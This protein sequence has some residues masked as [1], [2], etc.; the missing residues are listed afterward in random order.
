MHS[1]NDIFS[2]SK[3]DLILFQ[4]TK[5]SN[6]P[7]LLTMSKYKIINFSSKKPNYGG[8]LSAV[9]Q[10]PISITKGIGIEEFDNEGRV[11]TLE[12]D[13]FFVINAYF[14]FAGDFL[15][16]IDAKMSFL[17]EFERHCMDLKNKKPLIICGDF[18]IAHKDID[19]TFGNES[20]PGFSKEERAWFS[21]FLNLGFI[22]SFRFLHKDV[23]KYSSV[24]YN[25]KHKADRLDYCILSKELGETLK[26]SD[27]LSSVDGSDHM[28]IAIEFGINYSVPNKSSN[29]DE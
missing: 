16:K 4:E 20:M 22:D 15:A 3:Y 14:P 9:K 10:P 28:P 19:R 11:T 8:T 24:W 1:I 17:H 18:N 29:F 21:S 26:S 23:K 12:Y 7:L 27:I 2:L 25:D 5:N 13:N 6:V